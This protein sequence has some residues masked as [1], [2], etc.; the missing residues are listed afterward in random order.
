MHTY[1]VRPRKDHRGDDLISDALPFGRLWYSERK[2]A[3]N[4]IRYAKFRSP[5]HPAVIRVYDEAGNVIERTSTQATSKSGERYAR[6][7]VA[8][9]SIEKRLFLIQKRHSPRIEAVITTDHTHATGIDFSLED[10]RG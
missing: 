9:A 8:S 4:A 5:S 3:S 6:E 10:W 7:T 2:A 1:E